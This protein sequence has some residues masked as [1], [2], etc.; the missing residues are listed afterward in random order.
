MN[1]IKFNL[2][3]MNAINFFAVKEP[4]LNSVC[5]AYLPLQSVLNFCK[6]VIIQK[7]V[8]FQNGEKETVLANKILI[9]FE[10]KHSTRKLV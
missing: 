9:V 4:S 1:E 2:R 5:K 7:L 3:Q 8:Y 10:R 6:I